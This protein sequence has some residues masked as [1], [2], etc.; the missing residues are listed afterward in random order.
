MSAFL[1]RLFVLVT[2]L[3]L[4]ARALAAQESCP[5]AAGPDAEA[6]W[7]AYREG[8]MVQA[9]AR[10]RAALAHCPGDPYAATGMGYV[11]LREG[12]AAVAREWFSRTLEA[13][14]DD[15]DA[16][17]GLGLLAWR[18]GD[19]EEVRRRFTRVEEL[20][21]GHPTA[22]EYLGRLPAE[23]GPAPERAPLTLPDSLVVRARAHGDRLE[24]RTSRGWE[25]F[26]VEG[27]NLGATLPGRN[28]SEFPDSATY[29]AWIEG[30]AEL[31]ANA[32]RV[33]TIH[34]PSFYQA[35]RAHNL[36]NPDRPLWLIHGVWTELPDSQR[37]DYLA[38]AFE[39]PF[40]ADMRRVVDLVHGRADVAPRPG[41]AS[42]FYTADV[43]AWTLAY[44]VGR[45]WEP[46]SAMAFDSVRADFTSW[47]GAY[48]S[49]RDGNP[50][51]AWLAR[52]LDRLVAYETETY[53]EQRPVAYTSWPTLD[54][55]SHPTETGRDEEVSLRVS[56]GE[57]GVL[58]PREYDNDALGLDATLMRPTTAFPAGV[59][60]SFHAYPYYP[61]FM[62]LQ[63]SYAEASSSFGPSRYF[64]YLRELKARHPGMPVLIAEYGVPASFGSAHLQPDGLHHGG[65]TESAMAEA[66]R[67]LT[68]EIAEAGMA[69]GIVFAWMDEWFKRN[70]LV[71]EF[72]VPADRNRLWYNRLDAEQQYGLVAMEAEPP[73]A[74]ETLAERRASWVAIPPLYEGPSGTLRAAADA[75]Y[76][77]LY[78]ESPGRRPGDRLHVG[79]DV[80]D[81]AAGDR[82][83]PGQEG[84]ELPVG[85]EFVVVDDGREVRVLADPPV[86]P[87]RLVEVGQ[88]SR[89]RPGPREQVALAPAG[90]FRGRWEQ[91]FNV[92]YRSIANADG[93][94]DSLRVISNRRRIGRDSTE[95]L[96]LGYDRGV[97]PGGAA[98]DGFWE[99]D[100]D[101]VEI[102]VPWLLVN[103]TDPSSRSV[104]APSGAG[105]VAAGRTA[106]GMVIL[107]SGQVVP[108]D[109]L[110]GELATERVEGIGIVAALRSADGSWVAWPETGSA[111]AR[112]TWPAWEEDGVR[113]R[114]RRRAAFEAM[115]L[116][117][118]ELDPWAVRAVAEPRPVSQ[119]DPADAAWRS[120]D[121][122]KAR[123]LYEGRLRLDPS[124][125]TALHRLAL[126]RAW[127]EHY[128]EALRL[129]ER[130]LALDPDDL[131][132][133]VDHARVRAWK[134]DVDG[135][136]RSLDSMLVEHPGF[137]PA[138]EARATFEAWAGRYEASLS[139]Y[140][141]LLAIAP[142][143]TAARR[144]QA[145]VLSWA[146]R[147]DA[148][149]AVYD[150][151]L[152]VDS[153]DVEARLGLAQVLTFAGDTRGA[154]SA[155]GRILEAD[156]GN[157]RALQGLGRALG[158]GGRLAEGESALRRA[159]AAAPADVASL[160]GLAQNLRWQGRDAA[161][162][163]VLERAR[164][165]APS[166]V[167]VR[168][169][170]RW[171]DAALGSL[172]RPTA[173]LE[174]DSDD[175][176]M[177]T[178]SVAASWRPVPRL[179]LR[180]DAYRRAMEQ[181]ALRRSAQ[182]VT[183]SGRWQVEPG[184][185]FSA[186]LGGSGNDGP[187][188]TATAAWSLGA[189][190]P[191]RNPVGVSVNAASYAL[192]ATALLVERGVR[193]TEVGASGRWTPASGWRLDAALGTATF[194]GTA[195]NH[196]A[197]LAASASRRLA[198]V[199]TVGGAV[200]GFGF[201]D[202]L[203]DGYFD[204]DFYGI[205]EVT[206]RWL[207]EP[208][209]WS[210]SLE[211]A[212][213]LQQVTRDG[214]PAGAL[215]ATARVTYRLAPGRELSVSGGYSSTGLQSFSTGA[216][217]YR[218]TTI[219]L[220]GSWVF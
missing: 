111:A 169:Q 146:S 205:A 44:I 118:A 11:A 31:N 113:W 53:R 212:P 188:R 62:A 199:W 177:L 36:R 80:L 130:L 202:D 158:W 17:V 82:R 15:V 184:W 58:R 115:R 140:D 70:W 93:R 123:E 39:E 83:W 168:E 207:V 116:T 42:G 81:P 79:L 220:G 181:L 127:S 141:Q 4:P 46:R 204:P 45:E 183:V 30:L 160:V 159:V 197:S 217:D 124:D 64:G 198:R 201:E 155:Y 149:R 167:D 210:L 195:T 193:V 122:E 186:G 165:V 3:A 218:Y 65:L 161:A 157:V 166:D 92:P 75:A 7:A 100:G 71:A 66:D 194:R 33:Y 189:S 172:V 170:R 38:P 107:P 95:F 69:G 25:P 1:G 136:I 129:L 144:Q 84:P 133:A 43:S 103:V 88:G 52:A 105:A 109:T 162:L 90:L 27:V 206:G 18:Q 142:E 134:G 5:A 32:V 73:V 48:V 137:A 215:R 98:P 112:F 173:V 216:S 131:D 208:G 77:W 211:A 59:F 175:N 192:D 154:E 150:S 102:R 139:S 96:A 91:R 180:A 26:Y 219:A 178:A 60:A 121:T 114:A 94:Y 19:L 6:G 101:A 51:E 41:H 196:R 108:P 163:E 174:Q 209:R 28:P 2:L 13:R 49:L 9:R 164:A 191:G 50:M 57:R 125:R 54:P 120:G 14:P 23:L 76:L 61:D 24:V 213:G 37:N 200:R 10:F 182:G 148:S 99:R 74:G 72:E 179:E 135:A 56:L 151:L 89:A 153:T 40:F 176:R 67:R 128:D 20:A 29:A 12:D 47:D 68:R 156:P 119:E 185:T 117:F 21:P 143:N 190:S 145:Q 55:L 171:V 35:L 126:L 203:A 147:L 110:V 78:I 152:A 16:L 8:D 85:V 132:A 86:N 63:P 87:F 214:E 138:L 22:R 104:L 34:P 187:D 97:L 106:E